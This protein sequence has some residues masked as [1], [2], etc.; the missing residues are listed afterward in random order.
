MLGP[1]VA[2]LRVW[3][4]DVSL[5]DRLLFNVGQSATVAAEYL[6]ALSHRAVA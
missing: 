1:A 5:R 2:E 6:A 3:Q 4:S